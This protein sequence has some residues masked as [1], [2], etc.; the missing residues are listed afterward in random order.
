MFDI[1]Y[2]PNEVEFLFVNAPTEVH[3]ELLHEMKGYIKQNERFLRKGFD[4]AG[5]EARKH[6]HNIHLLCKQRRKQ[7]QSQRTRKKYE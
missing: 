5:V 6:L 2:D 4:T 3:M 7:I 1:D